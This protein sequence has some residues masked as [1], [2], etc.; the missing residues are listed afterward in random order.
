MDLKS[1]ANVVN[2]TYFFLQNNLTITDIFYKYNIF[3]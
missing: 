3:F 1:G 2:N